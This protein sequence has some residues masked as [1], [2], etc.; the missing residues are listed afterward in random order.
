MAERLR[1]LVSSFPLFAMCVLLIVLVYPMARALDANAGQFVYLLDDPYIHL[2][3]AKNVHLTGV[4]GI[5]AGHFSSASSSPLWT[6]LLVLLG[7]GA[8]W[9]FVLN[10]LCALAILAWAKQGFVVSGEGL[11]WRGVWSEVYG[12]LWVVGLAF[13]AVIL[14]GLEHLLHALLM[15]WAVEKLAS[16]LS[17]EAMSSKAWVFVE[18]DS[19]W[20]GWWVLGCVGLVRYES[21]FLVGIAGVAYLKQRRLGRALALGVS[22]G[23]PVLA[24]GAWSVW[25]GGFG[26]PNPILLKGATSAVFS[27][28]GFSVLMDRLGDNL[29][30]APEV[31]SLV[32]LGGLLLLLLRSEEARLRVLGEDQTEALREL[33]VL[34][35]DRTGALRELRVLRWGLMLWMGIAGLHLL[36]ARTGWFYRYEFYLLCV[37]WGY[38]A[39]GW[40]FWVVRARIAS[41][42]K[43]MCVLGLLC[44]GV[45]LFGARATEA[46]SAISPNMRGIYRQPYQVADFLRSYKRD[47]RVVLQDI[48]LVAYKTEAQ[49]TDLMGLGDQEIAQMRRRSGLNEKAL[50]AVVEKRRSEMAVLYDRG[51]LAGWCAVAAW[52]QVP[53]LCCASERVVFSVARRKEVEPLRMALKAFS[54]RL[55]D[56]VEVQ[57][58]SAQE[59]AKCRE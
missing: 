17:N 6:L 13:P 43:Q 33:Q 51:P 49:I 2:A 20:G 56:G 25:Q 8:A 27:Q 21:L 41:A 15:L 36:L 22:V 44:L 46:Q 14:C 47:V 19:F 48:G 3:I 32:V 30:Q 58:S 50:V 11:A 42:R 52:R 23:V 18:K 7:G 12:G 24:F 1:S 38:L 37:G 55:P 29:G 57:W 16:D 5:S 53:K 26:L 59:I 9:P 39:R 31:L 54:A 4:W 40:V 28:R 10:V 34:G 35:E 45:V